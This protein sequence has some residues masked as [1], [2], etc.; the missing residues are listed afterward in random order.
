MFRIACEQSGV[1]ITVP[2]AIITEFHRCWVVRDYGNT[3]L[4]SRG[5]AARVHMTWLLWSKFVRHFLHDL[6]ALSARRTLAFLGILCTAVRS[7]KILL[8]SVYYIYIYIK[9]KKKEKKN[10]HQRQPLCTYKWS[11]QSHV[12]IDIYLVSLKILQI[13]LHMQTIP[14]EV[15]CRLG[16]IFL[17]M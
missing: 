13:F 1:Q 15:V 16:W 8:N 10:C 14:T 5:A 12:F 11:S 3:S 17:S 4:R 9:K 6:K 7:F 2:L